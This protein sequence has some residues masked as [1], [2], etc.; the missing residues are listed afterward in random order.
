MEFSNGSALE[1]LERL[2]SAYGVTTQKA[3]AEC[4]GV[5]AANVSNW[6]QRDSVPGSAFVRCALDTGSDL[7]WLTS[8]YLANARLMPGNEK[9]YGRELH[10]KILTSGGKTVLRRILDAYGFKTQKELGDHLSISSGTIST[11][12]RREFFPGDIVITCALETGTSLEWLAIGKTSA[13]VSEEALGRDNILVLKRFR[14]NSGQ[15]QELGVWI[16]DPTFLDSL[17]EKS[18]F[19]E[20]DS[21]AWIVDF[22][23]KHISNGLWLIDIDGSHDVY[24]VLKIPGNRIKLSRKDSSFECTTT[25]I[26]CVGKVKKIILSN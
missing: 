21:E 3:L 4:L 22:N 15:L 20:K 1:I 11:W 24:D 5:S 17:P 10:E 8:G 13:Y 7:K 6:V 23:N 14:I 16:A 2:S 12:V 25:E 18:G 26:V 19:V 9:L